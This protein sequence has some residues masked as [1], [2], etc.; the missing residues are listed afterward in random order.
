[1]NIYEFD[2]TNVM[3]LAFFNFMPYFTLALL[4][5]C[6]L[7][8]SERLLLQGKNKPFSKNYVYLLIAMGF[9]IKAF[10]AYFSYDYA[11]VKHFDSHNREK[12]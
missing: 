4:F 3:Y 12:Y 8:T 5:A 6:C 2:S 9:V 1:M 7:Y 10:L 11:D